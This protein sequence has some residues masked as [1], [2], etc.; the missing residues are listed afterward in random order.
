MTLANQYGLPSSVI[1]SLHQVFRQGPGIDS[2]WIYGSR[3]KGTFRPGSDIDL[4]LKGDELD[5]QNLLAIE[6]QIDD[7]S[8][9][10]C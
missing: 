6:N 9:L 7:L 5:L 3:A 2:V 10:V 8:A 4:T 1:T